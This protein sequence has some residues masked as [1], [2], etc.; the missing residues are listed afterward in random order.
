MSAKVSLVYASK[1]KERKLVSLG[2]SFVLLVPDA[3]HLLYRGRIEHQPEYRC[4]TLS[5]QAD[6]AVTSKEGPCSQTTF[7]PS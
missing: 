1:W 3:I 4:C 2:V 7:N 5:V 6:A